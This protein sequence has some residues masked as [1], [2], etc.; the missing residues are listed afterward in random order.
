M[1]TFI[2]GF[3]MGFLFAVLVFAIWFGTI[4]WIEAKK[5]AALAVHPTRQTMKPIDTDGEADHF[6]VDDPLIKKARNQA[7]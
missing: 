5:W 6:V 7:Q 2:A 3:G 1:E 4:N